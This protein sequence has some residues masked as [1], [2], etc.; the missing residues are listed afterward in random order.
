MSFV[1]NSS[2]A[3]L[4]PAVTL[5]RF[6][7]GIPFANI[8]MIAKNMTDKRFITDIFNLISVWQCKRSLSSPK[9]KLF[10]LE[11]VTSLMMNEFRTL[12]LQLLNSSAAFYFNCKKILFKF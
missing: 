1:F 9:R 7:K 11:N 2:A 6:L 12:K 3:F 5:I 10:L 4:P 8:Y